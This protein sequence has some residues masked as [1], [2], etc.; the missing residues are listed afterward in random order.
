[1]T[2]FGGC[3]GRY[4]IITRVPVALEQRREG[5]DE[6]SCLLLITEW[7]NVFRKTKAAGTHPVH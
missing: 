1:M 6:G 4:E 2:G 3:W 5:K 7:C